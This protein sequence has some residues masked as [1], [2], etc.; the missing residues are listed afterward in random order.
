MDELKRSQEVTVA[1]RSAK[2]TP[3]ECREIHRKAIAYLAR[4]PGTAINA[5]N[6]SHVINS[7]MSE[8]DQIVALLSQVVQRCRADSRNCARPDTNEFNRPGSHS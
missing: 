2:F 1:Q 5:R 3:E 7:S 6:D 8:V 4:N